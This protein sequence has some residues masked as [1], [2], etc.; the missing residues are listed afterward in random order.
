MIK[1]LINKSILCIPSQLYNHHCYPAQFVYNSMGC[2]FITGSTHPGLLHFPFSLQFQHALPVKLQ[3]S[4]ASSHRESFLFLTFLNVFYLHLPPHNFHPFG[5]P[6]GILSSLPYSVLIL[7]L[8]FRNLSSLSDST[9]FSGCDLYQKQHHSPVQPIPEQK[10]IEQHR[11]LNWLL[12]ATHLTKQIP[13]TLMIEVTVAM[14]YCGKE[15]KMQR[16]LDRIINR[17]I[18]SKD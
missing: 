1:R 18:A 4:L 16:E 8:L 10:D 13:Q 5:N 9:E 3:T 15:N 6:P 7:L 12:R 11:P 14:L 2:E 17:A